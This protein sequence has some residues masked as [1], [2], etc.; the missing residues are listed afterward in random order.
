MS[1]I[2][3]EQQR[4]QCGWA[5]R[6]T[7]RVDKDDVKNNEGEKMESLVHNY[8]GFGLTIMQYWASG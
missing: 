7:E 4:G 1:C 3:E 2:S 8:K 6:V 5:K